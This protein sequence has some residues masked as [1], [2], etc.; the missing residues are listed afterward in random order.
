MIVGCVLIASL[1]AVIPGL[2]PDCWAGERAEPSV[3]H[4]TNVQLRTNSTRAG[5]CRELR[6][7]VFLDNSHPRDVVTPLI[8]QAA[9]F[10][11]DQV[12]IS[13]LVVDYDRLELWLGLDETYLFYQ[14]EKAARRYTGWD[15][16]VVFST[17]GSQY[18][19]G[20]MDYT[21]RYITIHNHDWMTLA[22]EVLHAFYRSRY[23]STEGILAP[24]YGA[25]SAYVAPADREEILANKWQR[26]QISDKQKGVLASV[27]HPVSPEKLP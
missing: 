10:L 24:Y 27:S 8:E 4:P 17:T 18:D 1:L 9:T 23:H 11:T 26:F 2:S 12:G 3:V 7:L 13:L 16:A 19:Y 6:L 25:D 14:V 21:R 20:A 22:H 5:D 15:L